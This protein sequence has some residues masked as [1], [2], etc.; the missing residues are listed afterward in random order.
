MEIP[1]LRWWRHRNLRARLTVATTAGLAL[2]LLAAGIALRGTL[3]S[4]L[5][6]GLDETARQ[7]A[8]A[9]VAL[10]AA[11]PLPDPVPVVGGA[12]TVQVLSS[13]GQIVNASYG[14]D[15][16]IP[17]LPPAQARA[18]ARDGRAMLLDGRPLG[19]PYLL[20]VVAVP[21]PHGQTVVAAIDSDQVGASVAALTRALIVG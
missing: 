8:Q 13:Q 21:G 20:G 18:N 9:V 7:E 6:R 12:I 4:S 17:L 19:I 1:V 11:R 5:T 10:E 14:A 3:R 2:A 15:R 16:L